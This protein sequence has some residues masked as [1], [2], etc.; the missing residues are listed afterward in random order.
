[1]HRLTTLLQHSGPVYFSCHSCVTYVTNT[2]CVWW[3][4][5]GSIRRKYLKVAYMG[6]GGLLYG[7]NL[8]DAST[9]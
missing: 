4:A 9:A 5:W 1:M 2:S 3:F 6:Y 7:A 8:S